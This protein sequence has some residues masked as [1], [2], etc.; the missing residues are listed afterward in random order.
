MGSPEDPS[1]YVNAVIHE[2]SFDKIASFLDAAKT[3]ADADVIIGGGH[4]K[5]VGYFI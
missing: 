1:N 2:G 3:D 5:S 4:D